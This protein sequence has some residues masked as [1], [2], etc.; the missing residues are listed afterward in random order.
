MIDRLFPP[1]FEDDGVLNFEALPPEAVM[2]SPDQVDRALQWSSA[3]GD[4]SQQWQTYLLAL[5]R[6]GFEQWLSDRAPELPQLRDHALP[7]SPESDAIATLGHCSVGDFKL[8]LLAMG[9]V[10]DDRIEIPATAID[11]PEHLAHFY[12]LLAVEEEQDCVQ[13]QACFRYDSLRS[14]RNETPL[15]AA[16][17]GVYE[18]PLAWFD[19][20]PDRLLLYLRC[21]DP[22]AITLPAATLTPSVA[23]TAAETIQR[24]ASTV[25]NA[26]RWLQNEL[27]EAA[28]EL[29]WVLLPAIASNRLLSAPDP[30]RSTENLEPTLRSILSEL[31]RS[32]ISVPTT[33]RGAFQD[34]TL[35][36][37]PL[38]LYAWVW[39]ASTPENEAEWSLLL[40]LGSA[41]ETTLPAGLKLE[42]R[43]ETQLLL[44]QVLPAANQPTYLYGQVF[45]DWQE[46]FAVTLSLADGTALT[47]PPITFIP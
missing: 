12:V 20:D 10:S 7:P 15:A 33:A 17:S 18:L 31:G 8:C 40:V 25:V 37:L 45:G 2:L 35:G 22:S 11:N 14:R 30:L 3:A 47:L 32:N 42:I 4:R 9:S 23:S 44:E 6:V 27:D 5:A 1:S 28:Q 29:G 19:E 39:P 36:P 41:T 34:V 13:V 46:P 38:R 24:L 26:G 16:S 21:L 43:D